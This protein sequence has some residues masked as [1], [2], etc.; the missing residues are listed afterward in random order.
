[1]VAAVAYVW[2]EDARRIPARAV[3][4]E[5]A[6]DGRGDVRREGGREAFGPCPGCGT[7]RDDASD[8][9]HSVVLGDG[10]WC[11]RC[12]EKGDGLALAALVLVG[13]K[14]PPASRWSEVRA[15]FAARGWCDPETG[16]PQ[17]PP[18]RP[19]VPVAAPPPP[20]PSRLPPAE[21]AALWAACGTVKTYGAPSGNHDPCLWLWAR[22]FCES[23][24]AEMDLARGLPVGTAC[25]SWAQY[26]GQAWADAGYRLIL[27][28]FDER[29]NLASLVARWTGIEDLKG[30]QNGLG[31]RTVPPPDK[32]PK[33]LN[34][35]GG[36]IRGLAFAN[37]MGRCLLERGPDASPGE[38]SG[39]P[40][41]WDGSVWLVE[42]HTDLLR[43]ATA[44]DRV[45]ADNRTPAVL[46]YVQGSWT[47]AL[48][49]RLPAAADVV[50]LP[51]ADPNGR[52]EQMAAA[53][54]AT[55]DRLVTRPVVLRADEILN[56]GVD[57]A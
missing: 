22:G 14:R 34:A 36:S 57:D 51:D 16:G 55:L 3:A 21:V 31:W 35:R 45:G 54:V 28:A 27:R 20:E 50:V 52:G 26:R 19:V 33:S 10:W 25:P 12:N 6:K 4:A 7:S 47:P 49:A 41:S 29:G 32:W 44:S 56:G 2:F 18:V 48:A 23:W 11:V 38:G 9:R 40:V 15:W 13:D 24:I 53:V 37:P 5:L 43:L 17:P 42:G 46:G 30:T 39:G 1:M 8:K